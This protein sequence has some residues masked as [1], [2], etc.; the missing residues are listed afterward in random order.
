LVSLAEAG[1]AVV[2]MTAAVGDTLMDL[3]PLL[4]VRG[5]RQ[6][7]DETA[8]RR[9]IQAGDERTFDQDPE[10]AVRLVVDIAIKAL[11]PAINDPTTAVQALD[12]IE[13]VLLRIGRCHL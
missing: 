9:A 7:L 12:Q 10:Y 13:D 3:A 4:R 1:D 6:P 8:L 11:S 5:A 2:E